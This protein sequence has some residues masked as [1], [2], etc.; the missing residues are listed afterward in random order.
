MKKLKEFFKK[1][2]F[3]VLFVGMA[4]FCVLGWFLGDIGY[5]RV[6]DICMLIVGGCCGVFVVEFAFDTFRT[7]GSLAERN[8]EL[9][10]SNVEL[11]DEHLKLAEKNFETTQ[12]IVELAKQNDIL[13]DLV[14]TLDDNCL[15]MEGLCLLYKNYLNDVALNEKEA[16]LID[17][18]IPGYP[19]E[20]AE[21]YENFTLVVNPRKSES[22]EEKE[23]KNA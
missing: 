2:C 14:K 18:T 9:A 20:E 16:K 21:R 1:C 3:F 8:V 13:K 15:C 5:K 10:N 4:V 6:G 12:H 11:A 17:L 23:K 19:K 22:Q 7:I